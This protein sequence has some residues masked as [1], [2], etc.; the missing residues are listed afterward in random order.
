VSHG[1]LYKKGVYG[2]CIRDLFIAEKEY[3]KKE[4]KKKCGKKKMKL[5]PF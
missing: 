2:I 5:K 1:N 3:D 4:R